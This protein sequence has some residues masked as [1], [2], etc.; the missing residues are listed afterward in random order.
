MFRECLK[1]VHA[2]SFLNSTG[3]FEVTN[4]IATEDHR[5]KPR[6]RVRLHLWNKVSVDG[7]RDVHIRV[8]EH[9]AH[10]GDRSAIHQVNRGEAM[11]QA[12]NG[13]GKNSAEETS[14]VW[15]S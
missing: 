9:G 15:G 13:E 4:L 2:G 10:F 11:T 12:V 7:E 6:R 8:A 5:G 14:S 1:C 3:R